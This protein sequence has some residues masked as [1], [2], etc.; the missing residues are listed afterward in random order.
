[1]AAMET[2]ELFVP[3]YVWLIGGSRI[4]G[5]YNTYYGSCTPEPEK[6]A[7]GQKIFNYAIYI[8]KVE[9]HEI[10]K[11]SVYP[12][13][14]SFAEARAADALTTEVFPCEEA[15]LPE[16]RTWLEAR[17]AEFFSEN[18]SSKEEASWN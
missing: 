4:G 8:E 3:L 11:A 10:L 15:Q 13:L 17:R 7:W 14:Q 9:D 2:T 12:G 16:V 1:M 6:P 18:I 5:T